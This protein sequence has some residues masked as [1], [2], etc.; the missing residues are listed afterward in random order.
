[1]RRTVTGGR[2]GRVYLWDVDVAGGM[3]DAVEVKLDRGYSNRRA[4]TGP[5][6]GSDAPPSPTWCGVGGRRCTS[7]SRTG[8]SSS[9]Q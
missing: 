3:G 9:C 8:P 6:G 4:G 1:M 2:D 7:R 5:T